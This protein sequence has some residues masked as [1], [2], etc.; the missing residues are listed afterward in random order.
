LNSLLPSIFLHSNNFPLFLFEQFST[1]YIRTIFHFFTFEQF[2]TFF[3]SNN[4]PLFYVRTIFHFLHS[5]NFP[6][7]TFEQFSIFLHSNNLT[8]FYIRTIFHYF[9]PTGISDIVPHRLLLQAGSNTT[10]I[11]RH[12]NHHFPTLSLEHICKPIP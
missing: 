11:T 4:F 1:F 2:S 5:N 12:H 10:M 7:F 8:L 3:H 6:L 9:F